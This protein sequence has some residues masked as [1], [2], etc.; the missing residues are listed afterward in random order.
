MRSQEV[1]STFP[2]LI[3]ESVLRIHKILILLSL[4]FAHCIFCAVCAV[5]SLYFCQKKFQFVG[6]HFKSPKHLLDLFNCISFQNLDLITI[7]RF[8]LT[9]GQWQKR[10][11]KPKMDKNTLKSSFQLPTLTF[12]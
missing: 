6:V 10:Q 12:K 7:F 5:F 9:Y 2:V 11:Q 3:A 4:F 8:P 1:Y